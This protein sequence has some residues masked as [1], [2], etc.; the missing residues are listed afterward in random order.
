MCFL[1]SENTQEFLTTRQCLSPTFKVVH[2]VDRSNLSEVDAK[3]QVGGEKD[4]EG[5]KRA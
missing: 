4:C 5:R 2:I 1:L 3:D